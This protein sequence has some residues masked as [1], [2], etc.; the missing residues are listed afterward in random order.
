MGLTLKTDG[1]ADY[2]HRAPALELSLD[3]EAAEALS[4]QLLGAIYR[5]KVGQSFYQGRKVPL[6]DYLVGDRVAVNSS[7]H[8]ATGEVVST[9]GLV[10]QVRLDETPSGWGGWR[11]KQAEIRWSENIRKVVA[12]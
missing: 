6:E 10:I 1:D 3:L 5:A 11:D 2:T 7:G 4:D 8:L 9:L 12:L